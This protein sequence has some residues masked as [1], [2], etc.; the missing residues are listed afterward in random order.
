MRLSG[1]AVSVLDMPPSADVDLVLYGA[2]GFV[3]ALT[4][5]YLAEHAP[6]GTTIAL[7]GRSAD[8]LVAVRDQLG[9]AASEWPVLVADSSDRAA[10][11]RLAEQARVVV[12]TVGPY[13]RY[14]LPLVEACAAAGTSYAD[15]TGEVLFVRD[16]IDAADVTARSSGARI[17]HACGFDSIP[18]DLGVQATAERAAADGAGQLTDTQLVVVSMRGGVSGGTVDSLRAQVDAVKAQPGLRR[19]L[20]DPYALTPDRSAEPALGTESDTVVVGRSGR[21]WTGP[22]VMAPFNTRIVR[23]S[24]ALQDWAYG[25]TFRYSEAMSF[26]SSPLGPVLAAGTAAGVA[27]ASAGLGFGPTRSVLDRLLPAPGSGPDEKARAAGHFRMEITASTTSGA[28]YRTTVAA[29]GDPGYAA[30]AVMLGQS[31]LCLA[32][33]DLTGSEGGGVLTPATAMGGLLADRLRTAGFT[34]S[35]EA[36]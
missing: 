33:D 21:R 23:R 14:G 29:K 17:V 9:G 11:A 16:S 18:S 30:T 24:N 32:L 25:R 20:A 12:T 26:G 28:R 15:L 35:T 1:I 4:A 34:L 27:G 7:A 22:F 3:G 31:G 13:A 10:V 5:A 6:A 8:R 36:V 19:V 2:S